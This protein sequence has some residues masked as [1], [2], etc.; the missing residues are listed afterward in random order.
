MARI[1]KFLWILLPFILFTTTNAVA[2]G[3]NSTIP[4]ANWPGDNLNPSTVILGYSLEGVWDSNNNVWR[5]NVAA[6]ND[7]VSPN[8][9]AASGIYLYNAV[10]NSLDRW[11]EGVSGGGIADS[12]SNNVSIV[13]TNATTAIKSTK[14]IVNNIITNTAGSA[15]T[16]AFY[17]ITSTGCTGTPASGYVF[18]LQGN[19]AGQIQSINHSFTNGICAVTAGTTAGNLSIL[20]R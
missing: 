7:A 19:T 12:S 1:K 20:Y 4:T 16:I 14:G 11:T 2:G 17:N 5:R 18:T 10:N 3:V 15:W 13:S 6:N 8:V 9:V